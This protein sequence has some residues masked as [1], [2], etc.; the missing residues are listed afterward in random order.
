MAKIKMTSAKDLLKAKM[1]NKTFAKEYES[2]EEEFTLAKEVIKLRMDAELTQTELAK[3]VGTSQP[4]IAR[5]E[6]GTYKN[7]TLSF[8]R[9][10]G[11]AL[12]A[13]PE[14]HFQ[15]VAS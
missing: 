7:V 6:S 2:L 15:K 5:L 8:L 11:A 9:R 10:V 1:K 14:I 12:G 4:A 13:N 3:L